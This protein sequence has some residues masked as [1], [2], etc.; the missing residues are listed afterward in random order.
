MSAICFAAAADSYEEGLN[1]LNIG[2]YQKAYELLESAAVNGS[3]NAQFWL[4]SMY[5]N[6]KGIPQNWTIALS[7]YRLA[8]EQ[9]HPNAQHSVGWMTRYGQGVEQ[10]IVKGHMWLNL[11]AAQGL[12]ISAEVRDEFQL[13]MTPQQVSEAQ[14]LA[15]EC[16]ERSYANC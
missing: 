10:D 9:G 1:A 8:A 13:H 6:G 14:R 4:A 12:K 7:W 11:A 16:L 3:P 2:D 15:T 5:R